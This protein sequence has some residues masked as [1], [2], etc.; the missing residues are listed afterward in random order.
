M[1][2][3]LLIVIVITILGFIGVVCSCLAH[4]RYNE[5]NKYVVRV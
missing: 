4:S 3:T 2:T 1:D 5:R